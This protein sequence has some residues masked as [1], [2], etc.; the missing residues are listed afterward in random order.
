MAEHNDTLVPLQAERSCVGSLLVFVAALPIVM[1]KIDESDFGDPQCRRV[2]GAIRE[3]YDLGMDTSM[4]E[5]AVRLA[6]PNDMTMLSQLAAQ[7]T[8]SDPSQHVEIILDMSSRR[9]AV[10]IA[11][12]IRSAA[13]NTAHSTDH[14]ADLIRNEAASME[15]P[16]GQVKGLHTIAEFLQTQDEYRWLIPY[17]LERQDRLIITG[18][19]GRGKALALQTKVHT[20]AGLV[21]ISGIHPGDTVCSPSGSPVS[22]LA[23]SDIL[24]DRPCYKLSFSDGA[25]LVADAEHQWPVLLPGETGVEPV[26]VTSEIIARSLDQEQEILLQ[27]EAGR[28]VLEAEAV[29][30]VPV[31]CIQVEA[32]DGLFQ[33]GDT[34]IPTHNSMLIRQFAVMASS[35]LHPF[36]GGRSPIEPIRVLYVDLENSASLIRRKIRPMV[37]RATNTPGASYDASRLHLWSRP[38]GI[39]LSSRTDRA[40]LESGL[41]KATP[42]MLIIAPLYKCVS[43]NPNDEETYKSALQVLDSIRERHDVAIIIEHHSPHAQGGDKRE[44]RSFGASIL[45]RWPEFGIGMNP[46][47]QTFKVMELVH[48]RG[49]RDERRWPAKIRWGR[50]WPWDVDEQGHE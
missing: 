37:Q 5:V 35:G 46:T 39:D 17:L 8:S 14:L 12:S 44:W 42:D 50:E 7:A 6:R 24:W 33:V 19:E 29:A 48:P 15:H 41:T 45:Q 21:P 1:G 31:K 27:D 40:M 10:N 16:G 38:G 20:P 13:Y 18:P 36:G 49:D 3:L 43:G 30:S 28:S 23:E 47:D 34:A 11:N 25:V 2:F 26:I 22:V 9:R 4:R 32:E